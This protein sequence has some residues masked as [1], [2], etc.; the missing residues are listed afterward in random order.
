[1]DGPGSIRVGPL[2][3]VGGGILLVWSGL[4]GKS[5]SA[6]LKDLISGKNPKNVKQ[7]QAISGLS[8][9]SLTGDNTSSGL[10]QSGHAVNPSGPGETAWIVAFLGAI[11]A[12]PTPAN[13]SSISSW[14]A[15]ETP[16]PP[17]A[18]NNPLNTTMQEPGSWSFNSVGV[19]NYTDP[20]TGILANSSTIMT[21]PYQDILM[22]LR[23]GKGLCG[24]SWGGLSTWSGGGYSSVC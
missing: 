2:F 7:T 17:V 20:A 18:K 8:I 11:G 19:Q 6:V 24:R 10:P 4:T 5:W 1:M 3:A 13:V 21:G 15:R 16:W 14:I 22:A 9:T 12:P 23:S